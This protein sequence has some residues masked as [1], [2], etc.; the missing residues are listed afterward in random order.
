MTTYIGHLEMMEGEDLSLDRDGR[1][2]VINSGVS[3]ISAIGL[4]FLKDLTI[5]MLLSIEVEALRL[6]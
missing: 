6:Q 5:L 3:G 1:K 4:K 2:H